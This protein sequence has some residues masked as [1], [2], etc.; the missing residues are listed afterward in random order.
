MKKII[1][2]VFALLMLFALVA[3]GSED[4]SIEDD[5][6]DKELVR[7][8]VLS[9]DEEDVD[10]FDSFIIGMNSSNRTYFTASYDAGTQ[11]VESSHCNMYAVDENG[12]MEMSPVDPWQFSDVVIEGT[13][14]F[15]NNSNGTIDFG[16]LFC[17]SM[18]YE[19]IDSV[20]GGSTEGYFDKHNLSLSCSET[21]LEQVAVYENMGHYTYI[22][23][24]S[25]NVKTEECSGDMSDLELFAD[26]GESKNV[27]V[28]MICDYLADE[29][30]ICLS[31]INIK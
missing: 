21:K 27:V 25:T 9:G 24:V 1:S 7:K 5:S 10:M 20:F 15:I 19:T 6:A 18:A 12:F 16:N 23:G 30:D 3:C 22:F 14:Y 26:K 31:Y 8:Y 29:D 2:M 11:G 13:E 17:N 4:T 28:Y